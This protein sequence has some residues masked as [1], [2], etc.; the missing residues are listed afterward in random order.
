M[1]D[2]PTATELA[3]AKVLATHHN[4][5]REF[6]G[7]VIGSVVP[8]LLIALQHVT[9]EQ[10]ITIIDE[11]MVGIFDADAQELASRLIADIRAAFPATAAAL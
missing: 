11:Y 7:E 3:V 8:P 9:A 6:A 10:C 4:I 2:A 5:P 1:N